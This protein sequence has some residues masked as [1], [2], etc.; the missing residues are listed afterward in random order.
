MSNP[1]AAKAPLIEHFTEFRRRLWISCVSL[2][3]AFALAYI[4]K[5]EVYA[6]L[7]EPLAASFENN[8]SRRLIYTKLTEAFFTYVKLSF[9]A[10]LF[11][12]FPVIATQLYLFVAPG[13]YKKEKHVLL[14][15]LILSPLLFIAGAALAYYGVFPLAWQFFVSFETG[16]APAGLP[17]QLE[18]KVNEYLSLVI[19]IIFAFGLTFQLPIFLTMLIR[20]GLLET[21]TLKSGR[22]YAVIIIAVMAALLTPQDIISMIILFIPLYL[23]YEMAILIGGAVQPKLD[24]A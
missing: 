7:V 23:F 11:L 6:F 2:V 15:Y 10:G 1:E 22:K 5:E 21:D 16:A 19:Q 12:A 20:V 18:A 14:P 9:Y 17:I 3:I 4:V 13:L 24:N 8:S